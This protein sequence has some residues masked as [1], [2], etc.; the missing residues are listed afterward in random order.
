MPRLQP[1]MNQSGSP[2]REVV[3]QKLE[4]FGH[5]A[6]RFD[7]VEMPDPPSVPSEPTSVLTL[8]RPGGRMLVVDD[9]RGRGLPRQLMRMSVGA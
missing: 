8:V 1:W 9:E 4:K 5:L 6:P 7:R 3:T 2:N